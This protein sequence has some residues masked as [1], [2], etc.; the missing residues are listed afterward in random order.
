MFLAF[1]VMT[2]QQK[3]MLARATPTHVFASDSL[4]TVPYKGQAGGHL[5][6]QFHKTNV[7]KL[8]HQLKHVME[9]MH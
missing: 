7:K 4:K 3:L 2:L 9:E 1:G 5:Q 8:K 6:K